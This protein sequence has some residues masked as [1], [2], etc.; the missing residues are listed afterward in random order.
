MI[1]NVSN[2]LPWQQGTNARLDAAI[3]MKEPIDGYLRQNRE[4]AVSLAESWQNLETLVAQSRS[5]L[6][7]KGR[8]T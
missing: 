2:G 8:I 1:D 7:A 6:V 5:H 4:A 3:Q